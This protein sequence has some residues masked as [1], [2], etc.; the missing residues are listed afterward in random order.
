MDLGTFDDLLVA[1]ALWVLVAALAWLA[2]LVVAVMAEALSDGRWQP[3]RWTGAPP[4]WRRGLLTAAVTVLAAT[5]LAP[6]HAEDRARP[7]GLTALEGLPLP[8]RPASGLI[9]PA[10]ATVT[11]RP[12][13]SLW[14]IASRLAPRADDVTL[15][16]LVHDL[17]Q[18]NRAVIG[19]APDVIEPGQVLELPSPVP[20]PRPQERP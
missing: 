1:T 19:P 9:S 5:G 2:V 3:A 11:V 7:V 4:A 13:D 15:S 17:H 14:L 12:G 8:A 6:A 20:S 10:S 18:H 16:R